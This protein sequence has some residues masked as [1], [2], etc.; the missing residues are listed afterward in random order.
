MSAQYGNLVVERRTDTGK[1]AN[2]KL[3]NQGKIPAVV[4]GLDGDA[5]P[6]SVDPVGLKKAL[7]P[8]KKQNT[9]LTLRV[10]DVQQT[11]M[12]GEFQVHP[13]KQT[14]IHADF[15]R[16]K[17]DQPV[18]ADVQLKLVGRAVG[19]QKGGKLSQVFRKLPLECTPDK[20]PAEV[21]GE[22]SS[23]D[24]GDVLTASSLTLPEGVRVCMPDDQTVALVEV[25]KRVAVETEPGA[26]GAAAEGAAADA[27]KPTAAKA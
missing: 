1:G 27:A 18:R 23:L 21:I 11:V 5:V 22:V 26:D 10:G 25:P 19:V 8:Q 15:L 24:L 17:I 14:V 12:L 16:V 6:I 2:R 13:I 3:R 20:I 9:L 4:Y 7:D